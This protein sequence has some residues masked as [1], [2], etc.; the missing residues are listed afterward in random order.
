MLLEFGVISTRY[1]QSTGE[2]KVVITNRAP[3]EMFARESASEVRNKT[4]LAASRSTA[5]HARVPTAIMSPG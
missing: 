3:A 4:K 2:H 1:L 5:R